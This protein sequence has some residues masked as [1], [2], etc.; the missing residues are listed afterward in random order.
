[1]KPI[2]LRLGTGGCMSWRMADRMAAMASSWVVPFIEPG[3]ELCEATG[4]FLVRR[5]H[6]AQLDEG[7]HDVDAHLDGVRAVENGG[8]HDRAMFG[9]DVR[10]VFAM[11]A[12]AELVSSAVS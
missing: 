8:G 7:T 9:E 2:G 1:V 12:A 10:Q 11:L 3:F 4:Q 5:E 6:L